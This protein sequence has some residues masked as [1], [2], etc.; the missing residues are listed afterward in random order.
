MAGGALGTTFRAW[1]GRAFPMP[2]GGFPWTT[3]AINVSGAFALA[4][5]L[6]LLALL[7]PRRRWRRTAQLGLGTGFLGGY[8][9]YSSFVV[10]SVR[11]G[12]QDRL[13]AGVTYDALSLS[14]GFLA[15]LAAT[16]LVGRLGRG[17]P[18]TAGA[19]R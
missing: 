4:A 10:E 18:G 12:E 11:L 13:L 2:D 8:T 1:I 9:T 14:G 19:A 6:G 5:L 15:A 7:H 16:I 17:Q 3:L